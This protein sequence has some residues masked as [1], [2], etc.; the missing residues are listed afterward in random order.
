MLDASKWPP[1][2]ATQL[3]LS[4]RIPF[5][6]LRDDQAVPLR[7]RLGSCISRWHQ[8]VAIRKARWQ[9][10]SQRTVAGEVRVQVSQ[11]PVSLLLRKLEVEDR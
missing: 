9:T 10:S 4:W 11:R 2:L 3:V 1:R 8:T 6:W 5:T 7:V